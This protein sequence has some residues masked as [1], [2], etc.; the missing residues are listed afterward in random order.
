MALYEAIFAILYL[1]TSLTI[2]L[3]SLWGSSD[4]WSKVD[5]RIEGAANDGANGVAV[6]MLDAMKLGTLGFVVAMGTW[7][8]AYSMGNTV[9]ELIGWFDDWTD[10]THNESDDE[11]SDKKSGKVDPDGTSIEYDFF[12]HAIVVVYSWFVFSTIAVLGEYFFI[13]FAT[14]KPVE[15]CDLSNVNESLYSG[16]N[17]LIASITDLATCKHAVKT[18]WMNSDINKDGVVTRCENAKALYGEGNSQEYALNYSEMKTLPTL[19]G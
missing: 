11:G 4:I 3:A 5:Q 15:N 10:P 16:N 13:T 19:Y 2:T 12:Y 1:A 18:I 8:A 17:S 9:D 7:I 14:L 6:S